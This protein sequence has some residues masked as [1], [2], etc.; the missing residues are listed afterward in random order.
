MLVC[1]QCGKIIANVNPNKITYS[2][3]SI[4]FNK[5]QLDKQQR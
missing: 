1:S 2:K 5:S 3:C 4:C